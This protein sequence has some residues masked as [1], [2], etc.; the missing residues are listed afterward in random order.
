MNYDMTFEEPSG[1]SVIPSVQ[2]WLPE[3]PGTQAETRSLPEVS[4]LGFRAGGHSQG[5]SHLQFSFLGIQPDLLRS[6]S[7][8]SGSGRGVNNAAARSVTGV[9]GGVRKRPVAA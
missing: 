9:W 8:H 2:R 7:R 5:Q 1:A 3:T 4:H 6:G